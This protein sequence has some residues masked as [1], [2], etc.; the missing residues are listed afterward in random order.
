[1]P[2]KQSFIL[3]LLLVVTSYITPLQAEYK[4]V[5]SPS[6]DDPLQTHIYALDN[7]LKVYL[8]AN[9]EEPRFYAEI[10]VRAGGKHDPDEATGMAHYL[11]HMLF[12]GSQHLGT[13]DYTKEQPHLDRI[14]ALYEAH[15]DES[16]PEKRQQ[17]YTQINAENQQAAQYAIPN[18]IDRLYSTM[19]ARSL[20]AHT[21]NEETIYKVDLPAN[22]LEH[23][24]RI[25]AERFA[26]PVFRLFQT[27]LET[28][29]EEMNRTLDSKDRLIYYATFGQLYK[30]H[31]YGR[32][33]IGTVEHLKKPSIQRMYDFFNTY[34][35]P[36]N[37]AILISG[38][39]D[40]DATI[41]TI[42][43][44]FSAWKS[45]ELP[46]EPK[47][48]KPR[49]KGIERVEVH[50]P[51]EENVRLAFHTVPNDHKDLETIELLDMVLSNSVAGLIDI[52]L[53]QR[54]QVRNASCHPYN[55]ND[56]G[57]QILWGIPLKDQPLEEVEQLLLDQLELVKQGEFADDII[58]AIVTDF[59]KM[60]KQGY[61]G[62]GGRVA[63]MRNA[64]ISGEDW[65]HARR[66]IQRLEKVQKKNIVKAAK[67][68]FKD[69]YVAAYRR[70]GQHELPDIGK[71]PLEKID[72]DPGR[73]SAFFEEIMALPYEEIEPTYLIP[74]RDYKTKDLR[75]GLKFYYSQNPLNDLFSLT[76][77]VEVGMLAD[78]RLRV[79]ANLM[80]KSG[81]T[82]FSAEELKRQWYRLGTDFSISAG[83]HETNVTISGLDENFGPS[84]ALMVEFL[85]QPAAEETTLQEL[86]AIIMANREDAKKNPH[87]IFQALVAYNRLGDNAYFR[88]II[89]NERLQQLTVAELHSLVGGLLDYEQ[90]LMYTGSMSIDEV[91]AQLQQHYPLPDTLKEA[92]PYRTFAIRQPQENEIYFFDKK[93]AQTMV[94]LEA[95]D[96]PYN[97]ALRPA[98]QLYN[99]YFSGGMASIVFQ[100]LREA[101]ALAYSARAIY[102]HGS[103][104]EEPSLMVGSIACQADKTAEALEVFIDLLENLPESPERFAQAQ[105]A[106]TNQY[107]TSRLGF[108]RVLG[109][110][111]TWEQQELIGDPREW[112][113]EKIQQSELSNVLEF[114]REHVQGRPRMISVV[115]DKSKMDITELGKHGRIVE[116]SLEDIFAF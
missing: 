29:Y 85:R 48:K 105:D 52:D 44:H 36:N 114:H 83:D 31:P 54:Q 35:V 42:D 65:D 33:V 99:E 20:N 67:K 71:P 76:I 63:L 50:Y 111:R 104:K 2:K 11:E 56:Y 75:D 84:L 23:W 40:I 15:F 37:M 110:V 9:R 18:E 103:R 106:M 66:K 34:Y 1:M 5:H 19:G 113:Y 55:Y 45:K 82:R 86:I 38:D 26:N 78:D 30:T 17:L 43:T 49:V 115:G 61:E 27:E 47:H 64:F 79:A 39:I 51:G 60:Y 41:Q 88:R 72:I 22:R 101:R 108:R 4:L 81:T 92:P 97:E 14:T 7:G 102:S 107:R 62:N 13:A 68:Y 6:P 96:E 89:P 87:A 32:P 58:P 112:R 90:E 80:D 100:E 116:I 57:A 59:K 3:L 91:T 95:G 28:V 24:A 74:G 46:K 21:S 109:A 94:R 16:D 73:Q 53:T 93:T 25:E 12:K 77:S 10:A 98:I 70:D 8:S 69:D